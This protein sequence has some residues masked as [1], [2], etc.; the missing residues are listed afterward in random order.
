M[1]IYTVI[2]TTEYN[3]DGVA[4]VQQA[5][6]LE[7]CEAL[8]WNSNEIGIN[9]YTHEECKLKDLN[10]GEIMESVDFEGAYIMRIA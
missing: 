2:N 6:G 5:V 7:E 8:G 3:N 1:N 10:V 4:T 9:L